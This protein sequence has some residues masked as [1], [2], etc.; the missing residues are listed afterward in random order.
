MLEVNSFKQFS[1]DLRKQIVPD[2]LTPR[3]RI[4]IENVPLA[5]AIAGKVY[6]RGVAN[7]GWSEA[8]F[9]DVVQAGIMGLIRSFDKYKPER[10][11]FCHFAAPAIAGECW[12]EVELWMSQICFP[13]PQRRD[14]R[15]AA[16]VVGQQG[17][18]P[19]NLANELKV[20]VT[21]AKRLIECLVL[22]KV[23]SLEAP[24]RLAAEED[25][26]EL[27]LADHIP[28][29]SGFEATIDKRVDLNRALGKLSQEERDLLTA[30][31][32]AEPGEVTEVNE[33]LARQNGVTSRTIR[34][35]QKEASEKLRLELSRGGSYD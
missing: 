17:N 5:I 23:A 29:E 14:M 26:E 12:T 6:R 2:G 11:E 33:R 15:R 32:N 27:T 18:S 34:K 3:Q 13:V 8:E 21:R 16:R 25:R 28:D 20:S 31:I 24:D 10:G 7:G 1:A 30:R 19:E 35:R 22:E 9:P 4:I